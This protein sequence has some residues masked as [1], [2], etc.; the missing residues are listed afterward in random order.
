[1]SDWPD[2]RILDLLG[3]RHPIL[4]APMAGPGTAALAGAVTEAGGLGALACA[5]LSVNDARAAVGR[6]RNSIAGP[7]NLNFFC[8]SAPTPD[9]ARERVWRER[10]GPYYAEL[11]L[12]PRASAPTASRAPFDSQYCD[13]VEELRPEVVSFHFGLPQTDLLDRVKAAGARVIATATTVREALWLES[14]GCDAVI[15]QGL[16]AGGHRGG[17]LDLDPARQVGTFALVPQ[18]AD[19]VRVPVIAAGGIADGRGVVAALALGAAAVQM[20]TAFLLCPEAGASAL[21]RAALTEA[22]DDDTAVTNLFTGAPARGVINR[23]MREVGPLSQD[24]PSFPLAGAALAPLRA[25]AE[26]RGAAD[27]TNLWSGQASRMAKA[28]PA[29]V[30]VREIAQEALRRLA[31]R[32]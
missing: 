31:S 11:G 3:I 15:A 28:V 9:K 10:L 13:L 32:T 4:L 19:A 12:D 26:A 25:A 6:V 7:I 5:L 16:E 1:M 14:R 29:G 17:F 30:L 21:H 8:H 20:G 18:M 22:A 27:F 2:R 23:L 24:A